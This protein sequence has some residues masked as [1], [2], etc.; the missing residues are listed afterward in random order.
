MRNEKINVEIISKLDHT[1]TD[2][3]V[4]YSNERNTDNS[5]MSDRFNLVLIIH[6]SVAM[7]FIHYN[8]ASTD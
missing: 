6:H 2:Y 1:T 5:R 3:R 7:N 4:C 8:D